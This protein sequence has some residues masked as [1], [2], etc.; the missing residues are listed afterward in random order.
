MRVLGL[1][2]GLDTETV[3]GLEPTPVPVEHLSVDRKLTS[4]GVDTE[5]CD[6]GTGLVA[7]EH[8]RSRRLHDVM[9]RLGRPTNPGGDL[10]W[11]CGHSDSSL[12]R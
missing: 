5:S 12:R 9:P 11:Y 4:A 8:D 10:F 7:E 2:N 1:R 3:E 6:P